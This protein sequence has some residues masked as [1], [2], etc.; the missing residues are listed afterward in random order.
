MCKREWDKVKVNLLKVRDAVLEFQHGWDDSAPL[1][2][3]VKAAF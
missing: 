3:N 1:P 2:D